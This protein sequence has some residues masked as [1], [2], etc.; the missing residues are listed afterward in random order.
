MDTMTSFDVCCMLRKACADAGG[1][2]AWAARNA[3]TP[4]YVSDVLN[5]RREPGISILC[6]LGL[7]RTVR[8]VKT[9]K[10]SAA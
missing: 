10:A 5:A 6:A 3:I 2:S 4:Q 1:Q 9:R 7:A 8:Y